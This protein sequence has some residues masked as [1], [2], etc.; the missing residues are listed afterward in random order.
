L[1]LTIRERRPHRTNPTDKI[2]GWK[3]ILSALAMTYAERLAIN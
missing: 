3:S 2:N 1:Y